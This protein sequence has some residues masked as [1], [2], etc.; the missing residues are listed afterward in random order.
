MIRAQSVTT[1]NDGRYRILNLPPG[2]YTVTVDAAAGKRLDQVTVRDLVKLL[3][4]KVA[5]SNAALGQILAVKHYENDDNVTVII[6]LTP[7]RNLENRVREL[8]TLADLGLVGFA[9]LAAAFTIRSGATAPTTAASAS[10]GC[11]SG[12]A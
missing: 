2:S 4:H 11:R 10:F 3:I 9:L 7:I 6:D 12:S 5:R 1:D 8:Q